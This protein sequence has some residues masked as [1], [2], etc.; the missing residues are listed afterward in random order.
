MFNWSEWS[1][2]RAYAANLAASVPINPVPIGKS[3][4]MQNGHPGGI[5]SLSAN[6]ADLN[7]GI[8]WATTYYA[9]NTEVFGEALGALVSVVPGTLRAYAAADTGTM[10][11]LW[12]SDMN[13]QDKL[14]NFAKF[15]PPTVA[16]G[17]VYVANF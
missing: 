12:N 7:S 17:R 13:S 14:F 16:G 6:G 9:T 5:L 3:S 1:E 10:R 15:N 2:L 4:Y 11:E 8:V